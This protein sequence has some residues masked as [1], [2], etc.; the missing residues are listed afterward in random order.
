[1]GLPIEVGLL[2][3]AYPP[4]LGR[5]IVYGWARGVFGGLI[6]RTFADSLGASFA[7]QC[8]MFGLTIL[9]ACIVSSPFNEWRGFWLQPPDKK[10]SFGQFFKPACYARSTGVGAT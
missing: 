2:Y 6:A 9:V 8:V 5:D 7:G 10:L 4:T 3:Q 1:M